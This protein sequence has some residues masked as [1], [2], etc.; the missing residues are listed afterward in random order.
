MKTFKYFVNQN[1]IKMPG[2]WATQDTC[3]TNR[4]TDTELVL[5]W[6]KEYNQRGNKTKLIK[7]LNGIH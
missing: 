4:L 6:F 7:T 5:Y 1:V 3:Y 2:G